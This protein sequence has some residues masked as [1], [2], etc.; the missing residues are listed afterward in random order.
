[1]KYFKIFISCIFIIFS[2][3]IQANIKDEIAELE[4]NKVNNSNIEIKTQ[5]P[6]NYVL[7]N[8]T[9][10]NLN[11]W[12]LVVFIQSTCEYCKKFDPIIKKV[13]EKIKMNTFVFSF[14]GLSDGVFEQV[15][16]VNNQVVSTFFR[17]IPVA[18]PTTFLV[19]VNDLI[20]APISQGNITENDLI[21]QLNKTFISLEGLK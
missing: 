16:P 1:M 19:N 9:V 8:K 14:D 10:I 7:P 18:T 12:V 15:I 21:N 3:H 2:S 20:T 6:V 5:Q 17:D 13:T 11:D 4:K